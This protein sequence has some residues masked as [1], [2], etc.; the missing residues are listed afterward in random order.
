MMRIFNSFLS[1]VLATTLLLLVTSEALASLVVVQKDG[2]VVINVLSTEDSI[3]LEIPRRDFL[4]VKNIA[5]DTPDPEAKISLAKEDGKFKLNVS[6][7]SGE[8]SLD[9]TNYSDEIVE[10][11][12]RPALERI[13]IG[14]SD[15]QFTI[16]QKGVV[17][18][19]DYEINIDPKTAGLTLTT[20]S[21]LRF[22]SILP[23]NALQGALR[24]KIINRFAN[25]ARILIVEV[26][27]EL[28]YELAGE[29][30]INLFNVIKYSVPVKASVSASTG[31]ILS[32]DQPT[33]LKVLGFLFS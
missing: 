3:E 9:V 4:E 15:N 13:R 27:R 1:F 17:A 12:E 18:R 29:R 30:V 5:E 6:S 21:G 8:K 11:E 33:W 7:K 26:G 25:E 10:I 23:Y 20:P 31:E 22:L 32:V 24:A 19:T 28:T 14:V 16:E 2:K